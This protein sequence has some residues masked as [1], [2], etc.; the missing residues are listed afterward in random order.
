MDIIDKLLIKKLAKESLNQLKNNMKLLESMEVEY[1]EIQDILLLAARKIEEQKTPPIN[2]MDF[3]KPEAL[4]LQA[5]R[6]KKSAGD[7]LAY[8]DKQNPYKPENRIHRTPAGVFVRSKSELVIATFLE[9]NK[10][11]YKYEE[12]LIL[13]GKEF[14]PDFKILRESDGKI[15]V[16][17]HL[18]MMEDKEYAEKN[19]YKQLVYAR[20]GYR[21]GDNFIIT[22]DDKGSLDMTVLQ[23]LAKLMLK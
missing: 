5:Y 16:W 12:V 4:N 22:Y 21:L 14:Y 17:E 10:I 15:V 23:K 13:E 2:L 6:D 20:N 8:H 9:L 1:T 19:S 18:G 7:W 3:L 11:P